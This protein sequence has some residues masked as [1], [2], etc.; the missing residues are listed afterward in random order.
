MALVLLS[1][2]FAPLLLFVLHNC[3]CR[4]RCLCW[5]CC[6]RTTAA[7][8]GKALIP[9]WN[10]CWYRWNW[11]GWCLLPRPLSLVENYPF[12]PGFPQPAS[13]H[14]HASDD[15]L[16]FHI[17][18]FSFFTGC[19]DLFF[20]LLNLEHP[21]RLHKHGETLILR[22]EV[23]PCLHQPRSAFLFTARLQTGIGAQLKRFSYLRASAREQP[24]AG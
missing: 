21:E 5:S 7:V 10:C 15:D 1:A 22:T 18:Y 11:P 9:C 23:A 4:H 8:R 14:G 3:R 16:L 12:C 20:S 24:G 2:L 17:I 19:S 13:C 6:R